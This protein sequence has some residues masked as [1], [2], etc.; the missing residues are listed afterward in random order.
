MKLVERIN[1][2]ELLCSDWGIYEL[3]EEQAAK[4]G[5]KFALSQG[6]FSDFALE[7]IGENQLLSELKEHSYEGFFQTRLEAF[8]QV[9]LVEMQNKIK[10]LE[11]VIKESSK[12]CDIKMDNWYR[13]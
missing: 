6:I 8:Y 11:R 13:K 7:R 12:V 5:G 10:W 3:S 2:N 1:K 4:Y 9:K